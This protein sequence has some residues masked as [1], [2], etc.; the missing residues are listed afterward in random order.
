MMTI[1][2]ATYMLVLGAEVVGDKTLYTIGSLAT[3]YRLV[4]IFC[5]SLVAFMLKMLAAVL[6]G[7]VI[8]RLPAIAVASLSAGTFFALALVI[9]FKA[10]EGE[11]TPISQSRSWLKIAAVSF[12]GIFLSEWGDVGQIAAATMAA[13]YEAPLIV[14]LAAVLAMSTKAIV[15]LTLGAG[16]RK[17]VPWRFLRYIT[18]GLCVTMGIFAVFRID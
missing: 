7:R 5:G 13:R 8:S 10:P 16:L 9:W 12:T 15:A 3:R 1:L 17:R 18:T 11:P 14:W 6:F 4:P 2:L